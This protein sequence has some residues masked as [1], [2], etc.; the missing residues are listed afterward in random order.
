MSTF[1][2][3]FQF[4]IHRDFLFSPLPRSARRCFFFLPLSRSTSQSSSFLFTSFL[5]LI[6]SF[7]SLH[8]SICQIF[9]FFFLSFSVF[10]FLC[11]LSDSFFFARAAV[12][13]VRAASMRAREHWAE[14]NITLMDRQGIGS[15]RH[16]VGVGECPG[17]TVQ[18]CAFRFFWAVFFLVIPLPSHF[19][20]FSRFP[21]ASLCLF[22]PFF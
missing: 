11:N 21:S 6:L 8:V 19:V 12:P 10:V 2:V 20:E 13:V 5:F 22:L 18:R 3:S 4:L 17:E 14:G 7:T 16:Q 15:I 9:R 1:R